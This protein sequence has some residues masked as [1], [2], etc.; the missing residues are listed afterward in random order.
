MLAGGP[1]FAQGADD[2]QVVIVATAVHVAPSAAPTDVIQPTSAI[3]QEFI[4]N[5][6]VPLASFDDI[7]KFSPSIADQS[8]NGPGLGKSETLTL[9]GF[10]DG[11]FNVTFDG[12]PFGDSTDLHHTSSAYFIAHDIGEAEIDRGPGT[13]STIGNAT[14][15]GT[16]NFKTKA[17]LA[18]FTVNPY[19][20]IGSFGTYAGGAEVDT[21]RTPFGK[22]FL[23]G[24]YETSDGYL[25]NASEKRTNVM[26]KDVYDDI[27]NLT[28]T[29]VSSI[30]RA[31]EYTTQGASLSNIKAFGPNFGL[32]SNP[33]VQNYYGYQP[34]NYTAD[35]EYIDVKYKFN[36][37]FSLQN[38]LYTDAFEHRYTE[39]TDPTDT[40]PTDVGVTFYSATKIG[41][42][43]SPQPA[44]ASTDIPGKVVDA[45]FRNWGDILRGEM[46]LPFGTVKAGVWL[47]HTVDNRN[48][49]AADLTQGSE[50]VTG[51]YGTP[52]TYVFND[53]M[54]TTQP[55]VELDWNVTPNLT[56]TPGVR[57]TDDQRSIDAV[58]NKTKPPGPAHYNMSYTAVQPSVAAR[59]TIMPGWTAYAQ[60]ASGF[61]APPITLLEIV[62]TPT[63]IKPENT[64]NYQ[65]G[66]AFKKGRV[67]LGL[68]AY[69][70]DFSNYITSYVI[71]ATNT[72]GATSAEIGQS[73][74]TNGGGAIYE[75]VE[76]EGQYVLDHGFS[77]YGNATY[78]SAKYKGSNVW[79]AEAPQSTA[80]AGVLYDDKHGPFASIIGK[81]IGSRF[82]LDV[83]LENASI[84]QNEF[85]LD[86]YWTADLAVGWRFHNLTPMVKDFSASLKVSNLFDNHVINDYA[87]QQ[88]ATTTAFPYGQPLYWTMP[89]RGVFANLSASF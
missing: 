72:P 2:N 25:T 33:A 79:L 5:N 70:I 47:E 67:V 59:Y 34:S 63:S 48:S 28:I 77:L 6:I 89:G 10:Q 69:Y 21:G 78:N 57:Y 87:G 53:G 74:Y 84:R 68:D 18:G 44:G 26:L 82:G 54:V 83:P 55:Y 66:T 19:A 40:V 56:V 3:Q 42:K 24:Q 23:D 64:W 76:L 4:Q 61:L 15:G 75:G 62:G 35:F 14:F 16:V 39:S 49:Y 85:G 22:V 27:D 8:P 50:Q 12:I 46:T 11:Q 17:P 36:A 13:G 60:A 80:A 29:A 58:L 51:K 38:T 32:G 31:F 1:A 45:A 20:T 9:R 71:N 81:W 52:Y 37:M 65:A 73:A 86:G 7:I 43:L 30:N 88:A 41:S